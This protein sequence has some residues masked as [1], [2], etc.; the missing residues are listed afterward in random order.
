MRRIRNFWGIFAVGIMLTACSKPHDCY[1]HKL[2]KK[3][4]NDFCTADC[5]GVLGC[6]GEMYCNECEANRHGIRI[7]D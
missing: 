1:D 5:P 2:Y 4:K 3:H 7:V 6:D